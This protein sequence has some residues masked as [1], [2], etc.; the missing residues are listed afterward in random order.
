MFLVTLFTNTATLELILTPLFIKQF[1]I[2]LVRD[3]SSI[4]SGRLENPKAYSLAM[5]C[6]TLTPWY[7]I[8]LS[9]IQQTTN[10]FDCKTYVCACYWVAPVYGPRHPLLSLLVPLSRHIIIKYHFNVS[11]MTRCAPDSNPKTPRQQSDTLSV[12]PKAWFI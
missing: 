11:N 10:P 6:N 4:S 3:F 2:S 8:R 12:T 5:V 7:D 9:N 1:I